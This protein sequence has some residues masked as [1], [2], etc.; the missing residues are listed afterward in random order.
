[1][2]YFCGGDAVTQCAYFDSDIEKS[3]ECDG[4]ETT[5]AIVSERHHSVCPVI[6]HPIYREFTAAVL[7][8]AGM[9]PRGPLVLLTLLLKFLGPRCVQ[10]YKNGVKRICGG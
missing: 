9:L 3:R 1:M 6:E 8:Y 2:V 5:G 7:N 4:D 10:Y